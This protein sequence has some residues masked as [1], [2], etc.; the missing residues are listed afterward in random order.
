MRLA[1]SSIVRAVLEETTPQNFGEKTFANSHKTAKF[2]K[3]F[4]LESFPLY[5]TRAVFE[6]SDFGLHVPA[7]Q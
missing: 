5:N 3:D 1:T 4:S 7:F 2:A 6:M